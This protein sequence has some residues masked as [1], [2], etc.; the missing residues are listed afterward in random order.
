MTDFLPGSQSLS[1]RPRGVAVA[2]AALAHVRA[3]YHLPFGGLVFPAARVSVRV[4]RG[5]CP[6]DAPRCGAQ[7]SYILALEALW[8]DAGLQD[9]GA[10]AVEVATRFRDFNVGRPSRDVGHPRRGVRRMLRMER[11]KPDR[12]AI[13]SGLRAPAQG[14]FFNSRPGGY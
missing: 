10:R 9:V 13:C 3:R 11:I 14:S 1:V 2:S 12:S 6:N 7:K 4:H 8:S 5:H